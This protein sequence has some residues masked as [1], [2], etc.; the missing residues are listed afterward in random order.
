M[1][2]CVLQAGNTEDAPRVGASAA[3]ASG[4]EGLYDFMSCSSGRRWKS[5]IIIMS[6]N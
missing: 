5:A 2:V 1:S 6:S 4:P 3:A